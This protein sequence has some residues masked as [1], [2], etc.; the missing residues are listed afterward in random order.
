MI[1][2]RQLVRCAALAIAAAAIAA[3]A[4]AAPALAQRS[5]GDR[6]ADRADVQAV[7][8]ESAAPSTA[9]RDSEHDAPAETGAD[10]D[11]QEVARRL[12]S[13]IQALVERNGPSS[14]EVIEP[15]S[16]LA[17]AHFERGDHPSAAA[18]IMDALHVIRANLGLYTLDQ[19]P[20][21]RLK[22]RND[23]AIGDD[24][25]AWETEQELLEIAERHPE[26]LRTALILRETADHR[27][28]I[29]ERYSAGEFPPEI[30][31]GCYYDLPEDSFEARLRRGRGEARDCHSGSRR[32]AR[33]RLFGEAQFYYGQS[34]NILIK[35][36]AYG[37]E[38]LPALLTDLVHS[39]YRYGNPALGE[40][41]LRYLLA[42]QVTNTAPRLARIDTLIQI[43]DWM[44][45]HSDSSNRNEE[46]LAT[47]EEAYRLLEEHGIGQQ[48]I[49]QRFSPAIPVVLPVFVRNPLAPEPHAATVGFIDVSFEITK[50]GRARDIEIH[51][52]SG[53]A[54][55]A[56]RRRLVK[57]LL[58]RRFRPRFVD[59][60]VD[61]SGPIAVRYYLLAAEGASRAR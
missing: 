24:A 7:E 8:R 51:D 6:R 35:N 39:S 40:R 61:D 5:S 22:M 57:V 58:T 48:A 16:A 20:L 53:E 42:Y 59:N 19:T 27:M 3:A 23:K 9:Q 52:M 46:A 45:L 55:R 29:L 49:E 60:R 21:L 13:R 44:L 17:R 37:N 28:D 15:L 12:E 41:S 14:P 2:I 38:A 1:P 47:Y 10:V 31:L 34:I 36:E 11:W 25:A 32:F 4:I 26:D 18:V 56:D 33:R 54:T 50:H 30:Y 43:A